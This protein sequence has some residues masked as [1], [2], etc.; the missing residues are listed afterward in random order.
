MGELHNT[1]KDA[2]APLMIAMSLER[3]FTHLIPHNPVPDKAVHEA[4]AIIENRFGSDSIWMALGYLYIDDIHRSHLIVQDM[5]NF[6][7][8]YLHGIIHRR[9]GD[10]PNA[11]YWFH[12][13][14]HLPEV[15]DLDP[16]KLTDAY[17]KRGRENPA[18][19]IEQTRA[20]WVK[21]V[22]YVSDHI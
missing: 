21:L 4:L 12:K 6:E 14:L 17:E 16:Y 5:S 7:A 15:F 10:F 13:S 8:F 3:A 11:K 20:E 18:D 1:T 19:L 9:E 22:N 2:L